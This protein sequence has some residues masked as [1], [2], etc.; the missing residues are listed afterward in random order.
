M[1]RWV[2]FVAL[3]ALL[4]F[5][6]PI[7]AFW[8]YDIWQDRQH[9][10]LVKS[11]TPL[12][13]GHGNGNCEATRLANVIQPGVV[14]KVQRIRYGKD[15]FTVDV[16]LPDGQKGYLLSGEGGDWIVSPP[17]DSQ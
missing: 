3:T 5:G 13:A 8:L 10:V 15:C 2:R 6:T 12:F 9:T 16:R 4:I 17:L 11:A 1:M 7:G 14:L